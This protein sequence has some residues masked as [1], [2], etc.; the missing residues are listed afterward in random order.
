MIHAGT[1]LE[2]CQT[3]F[4]QITLLNQGIYITVAMASMQPFRIERA[5]VVYGGYSKDPW[6]INELMIIDGK[7]FFTLS[8][9]DR[10]FAR[11]IGLDTMEVNQFKGSNLL[12]KIIKARDDKVDHLIMEALKAADP[13]ADLAAAPKLFESTR[14]RQQAYE[15]ANVAQVIQIEIAGFTADCGARYEPQVLHVISTPKRGA[16]ATVELNADTLTWFAAAVHHF[17]ATA[18]A[19]RSAE[20]VPLEAP[21]CKWKHRVNQSSAI[22]CRYRTA[23][24]QWKVFSIAPMH[25]DDDRLTLAAQREAEAKVQAF[26][27][28]NHV[29]LP[30]DTDEVIAV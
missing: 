28:A 17:S 4:A 27:E 11:A 26:Y 22:Y 20:D 6:V 18:T 9:R 13:L 24:R 8:A 10:K 19:K 16:A 15:K 5:V 29:P 21:D 12:P 2:T 3:V 14:G 1:T 30:I 25:F 23:E 7:D